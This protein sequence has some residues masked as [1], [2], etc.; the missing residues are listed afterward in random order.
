MNIKSNHTKQETIGDRMKRRRKELNISADEVAKFI[1][2]DRT[3]VY[4]YERGAI[5]KV[6]TD[7]LAKIAQILKTSPTWLMGIS[8]TE[9]KTNLNDGYY[10]DCEVAALAEQLRTNP[11]L[12]I[13]F[14][15]SKNLKKE[16]IE[17]VTDMIRR[18]KIK[19]G[20]DD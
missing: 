2:V 12:R 8:N 20:I 9:T 7:T 6:S 19:E 15:A 11:E 17:F 1:G 5:N 10:N 14:D 3:T 13:L 4:R 16:D 18:L